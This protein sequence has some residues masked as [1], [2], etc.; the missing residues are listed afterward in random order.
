VYVPR[1]L[2]RI[3]RY[4]LL[5]PISYIIQQSRLTLNEGWR[6]RELGQTVAVTDDG[7]VK[8]ELTQG[9]HT[10]TR[11]VETVLGTTPPCISILCITLQ[12]H[13]INLRRKDL[14]IA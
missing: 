11:A 12:N 4:R 3:H 9:E 2:Y 5:I 10:N 6:D 8:T 7:I 1:S 13:Q 14:K